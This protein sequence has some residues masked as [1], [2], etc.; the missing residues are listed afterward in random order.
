MLKGDNES[1]GVM[2]DSAETSGKGDALEAGRKNFPAEEAEWKKKKRRRRGARTII[3]RKDY[4]QSSRLLKPADSFAKD[5]RQT[6]RW[7][8]RWKD[9]TGGEGR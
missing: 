1:G 8:R 9:R 4:T 7:R 2:A 5:V 3:T 6:K